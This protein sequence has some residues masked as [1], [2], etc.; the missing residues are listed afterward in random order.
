MGRT[1]SH[2]SPHS[3]QISALEGWDCQEQRLQA[4]HSE[5]VTPNDHLALPPK[6]PSS[7]PCKCSS[8]SPQ[9]PIFLSPQM[10]ILFPLPRPSLED[11]AGALGDRLVLRDSPFS[12]S[13]D[14]REHKFFI[15]RKSRT[16]ASVLSSNPSF[17]CPN[18]VAVTFSLR[19]RYRHKDFAQL[20]FSYQI[21]PGLATIKSTVYS[22]S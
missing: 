15:E 19:R 6:C 12:H 13:T 10:P 5:N 8:F 22:L 17:R 18:S 11:S 1:T 7:S 21:L 14:T 9:M 2:A 20:I 3:A 16:S 4:L